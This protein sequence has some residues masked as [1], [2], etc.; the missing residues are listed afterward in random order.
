MK[1]PCGRIMKGPKWTPVE[2][3]HDMYA[4]ICRAQQTASSR[5]Y[6]LMALPV[7]EAP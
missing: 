1:T 3:F 2:T 5:G 7:T 6:G 4:S